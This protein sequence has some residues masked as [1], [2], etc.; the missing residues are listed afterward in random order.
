MGCLRLFTCTLLVLMLF[1]TRINTRI[2][3]QVRYTTTNV[4]YEAPKGEAT[5]TQFT[6][7]TGTKA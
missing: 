1:T 4:M 2:T 5:G 3:T 7:F 6:C